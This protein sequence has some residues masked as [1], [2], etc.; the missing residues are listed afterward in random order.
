MKILFVCSGNTCRSPMAEGLFRKKAGQRGLDAECSSAGI[1][2]YNGLPAS[3][4]AVKAMG[5]LYIDISNH[6]SADIRSLNPYDFDLFVPMTLS[7]A[8]ALLQLG[9]SKNE[10][11]IFESD[12]SDPYGGSLEVYRATRNEIDEN[13]EGLAD[14]IENKA[15]ENRTESEKTENEQ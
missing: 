13:L 9:V 2:T 5:E 14:F 4:N 6:K 7:H 10:I 15:A 1:M 8:Q 11:Y 3:E 12:V